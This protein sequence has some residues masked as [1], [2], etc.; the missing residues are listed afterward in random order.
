M[1]AK[2]PKSGFEY[3]IDV[4]DFEGQMGIW[5]FKTFYRGPEALAYAESLAKNNPELGVTIRVESLFPP[6]NVLR[7]S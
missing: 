6:K 7:A 1:R 4:E 3:I 5:G 2:K